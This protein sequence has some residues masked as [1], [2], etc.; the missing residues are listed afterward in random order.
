MER[1]REMPSIPPHIRSVDPETALCVSASLEMKYL[2]LE[3]VD[4]SLW[5]A[6]EGAV[7]LVKCPI[8]NGKFS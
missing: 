8:K 1:D 5:G 6:I 4:L 7:V 2:R 3:R